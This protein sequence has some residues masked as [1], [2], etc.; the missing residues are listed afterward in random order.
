MISWVRRRGCR[1]VC[2]VGLLGMIVVIT[3]S[4]VRNGLVFRLW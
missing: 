4:V 3:V 1:S 2:Q